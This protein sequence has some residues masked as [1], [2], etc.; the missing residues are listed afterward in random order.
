MT[1]PPEGATGPCR[2]RHGTACL[3]QVCQALQWES[4]HLGPAKPPRVLQILITTAVQCSLPPLLGQPAEQVDRGPARL[5]GER[6]T[7]ES[8]RGTLTS[9]ALRSLPLRASCGADRHLSCRVCGESQAWSGGVQRVWLDTNEAR[10]PGKARPT[11]SPPF[12]SPGDR[13]L[14]AGR[15]HRDH[16]EG[17]CA[18]DGPSGGSTVNTRI[19]PADAAAGR[20]FSAALGWDPPPGADEPAL[21][22]APGFSESNCLPL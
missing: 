5:G 14:E 19:R 6:A 16:R 10:G 9:H 4:T 17:P 1:Q 8:C 13:G 11:G 18:H 2:Q 3:W 15:P 12:H 21:N 22:V 20:S 7:S